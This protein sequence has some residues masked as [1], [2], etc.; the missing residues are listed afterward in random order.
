MKR[1]HGR[2]QRSQTERYTDEDSS[3]VAYV[4][5]DVPFGGGCEE[6]KLFFIDNASIFE[7]VRFH[8]KSRELLYVLNEHPVHSSVPLSLLLEK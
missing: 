3:R 2:R 8:A 6:I 1:G 7:M 5:F 4:D